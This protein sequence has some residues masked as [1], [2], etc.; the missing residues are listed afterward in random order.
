MY[1]FYF[2]NE[3]EDREKRGFW[4]HKETMDWERVLEI[5]A[6]KSAG[7]TSGRCASG[8]S[9]DSATDEW[10]EEEVCGF[11]SPRR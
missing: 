1:F 4:E 6:G 5:I 7:V 11:I 3:W 10:G 9:G 2:D 8:E